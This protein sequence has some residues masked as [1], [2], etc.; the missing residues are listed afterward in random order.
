MDRTACVREYYRCL[1]ADDYETLRSLLVPD[2]V[3]RRPDR[4][5]TGRDAFVSFMQS[6]RPVTDTTH[7]L[8]TLCDA[9]MGVAA[10]G[11]VTD[12]DGES[13]FAFI[14]VFRFDGD[15]ITELET[16]A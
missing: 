2:F 4:E 13:L 3:Q 15:R 11:R 8:T 5:F 16:Y 10:H 14:D 6:E 7:E 1:D 12:A 9:P